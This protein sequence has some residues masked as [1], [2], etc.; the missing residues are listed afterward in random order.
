MGGFFG[1]RNQTVR[2]T[3]E[4]SPEQ[5]ALIEPTISIFQDYLQNP[6]Q[7]PDYS[8]IAGFDPIQLQAQ[9]QLLEGVGNQQQTVGGAS[10]A[11]QFLMGD[12]LRPESNPALQGYIDA[13]TRPITENLLEEVLPGLRGSAV[14]AGQFG[15]SRQG[16]A[17][18]L[19][20]GRAA[21]AIGD[22]AA[23][24]A[25]QGYAQGLRAL[26][27]GVGLAPTVAQAQ[28]IPGLTTGAVGDVRR[29]L[30][31]AQLSEQAFRDMYEQ[32]APFLAAQE[33]AAIAS[34]LP[35]GTSTTTAPGPRTNPLQ[36]ALGGLSLAG[37]LFSGGGGGVP[38]LS[39]AG[40]F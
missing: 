27:E 32:L 25:N 40:L 5:K 21:R 4:L 29:S 1:N 11:L 23:N 15:G 3:T 24:V 28:T 9:E 37:S 36:L 38:V 34:G 8:Q 33:V 17:E 2:A 20:T 16:I 18:G 39:G 19:A 30:S 7:L 22:T 6:A 13:A 12:V 31:Q 14:T 10:D 26:T 35:G